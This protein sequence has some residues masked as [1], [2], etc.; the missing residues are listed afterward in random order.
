MKTLLNLTLALIATF[1]LQNTTMAQ[2]PVYSPQVIVSQYPTCGQANGSA[3]V[4]IPG[5]T[6]HFKFQWVNVKNQGP[7][8]AEICAS[9]LAPG[10]HVIEYVDENGCEGTFTFTLPCTK[11]QEREREREE[12]RT[13]K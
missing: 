4:M 7:I 3:C 5:T 2:C 13:K 1:Y 12:E 10:V 8:A 9:H 6:T 11:E